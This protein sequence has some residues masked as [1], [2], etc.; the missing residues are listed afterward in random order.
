MIIRVI[1][2]KKKNILSKSFKLVNLIS[3]KLKRFHM[4]EIVIKVVF[5]LKRSLLFKMN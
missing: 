5:N 4:D 1:F 2:E 3:K